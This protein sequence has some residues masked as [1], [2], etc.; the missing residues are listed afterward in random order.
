MPSQ[1]FRV[2][3]F[4]TSSVVFA[5]FLIELSLKK[6]RILLLANFAGKHEKRANYWSSDY[7]SSNP[8]HVLGRADD[9]QDSRCS[10]ISENLEKTPFFVNHN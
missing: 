3:L 7:C 6:V 2:S 9:L 8:D 5:P 4:L 10:I 1:K